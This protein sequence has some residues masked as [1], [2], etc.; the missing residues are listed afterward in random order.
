VR[1]ILIAT[2]MAVG[3][4]LVGT[5]PGSAAVVANNTVLKQIANMSSTTLQARH[6]CHRRHRS[7]WRWCG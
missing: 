7:S 2:L 4:G 6:R 1:A 5:P 3:V